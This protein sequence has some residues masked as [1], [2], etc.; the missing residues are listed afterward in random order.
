MKDLLVLL[1][2]FVFNNQDAHWLWYVALTAI[3]LFDSYNHI[4]GE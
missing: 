4:K 1:I 2:L 3:V